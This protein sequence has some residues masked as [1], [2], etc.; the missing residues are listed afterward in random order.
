MS[1]PIKALIIITI[2][3]RAGIA[4]AQI[5]KPGFTLG[6]A[7]FYANPQSEFKNQYKGGVGGEVKGGIGLGKTYIVASAGYGAF[8]AEAGNTEGTL[9]H[10]PLKIGVKQYFLAK[11]LFINGDI[12]VVALKDKTSGSSTQRFARDIGVGARLLGLEASVFYDTWDNLRGPEGSTK[13]ILFKVGYN[14]TL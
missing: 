14:L 11:R 5:K 10:Q 12:G 6:F 9:I 7:A 1:N 8:V 4:E 2:L 3:F 13:A